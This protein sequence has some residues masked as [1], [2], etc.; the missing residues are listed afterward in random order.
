MNACS[1]RTNPPPGVLTQSAFL[2]AAFS[3]IFL[4]EVSLKVFSGGASFL[5]AGTSSEG[6]ASSRG[7]SGGAEGIS[8]LEAVG[9]RDGQ[10]EGVAHN[11]PLAGAHS[12]RVQVGS[13]R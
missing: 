5:A 2:A 12:Q 10:E 7:A 1:A 3:W 13:N 6:A 9:R 4:A 8:A 11:Q